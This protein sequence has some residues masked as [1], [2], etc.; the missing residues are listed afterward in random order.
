MTILSGGIQQ[1]AGDR[2]QKVLRL[3]TGNRLT[4][5]LTGMIVTAIIQS[6]S[7]TTVMV[8][9]FVSAGLLTLTQSIGVIMGANIGTTVTAWIVSWMGFAL[10]PAALALP[11]IGIGMILYM[12][13][14]KY[15]NFG[16]VLLGFG[17]VFLGLD[18]LTNSVPT[19]DPAAFPWI[20]SI[21]G[22]SFLSMLIGT[23]VG[24]VVT[25]IAHSSA[26]T[27]AIVMTM[28]R[29]GVIQF[30]IAA[31]MILGANIGTTIDAAL[32]A[33]GANTAAK[34]AALVHILF[35]VIGTVWAL[36]FLRPLIFL[37][38]LVTPGSLDEGGITAHLAMLHTIFNVANTLFFFPFVNPFA[39]LVSLLIKDKS[40]ELPDGAEAPYKLEYKSGTINDTPEWNV[41]RAEKEIRDMAGF[42][43]IMYAEVR[44]AIYALP[45]AAD[46]I[47]FVDHIIEKMTQKEARADDIR[48]ELTRFL[49]ECTR[50][51]QLSPHF[52]DRVTHLLRIVADLEEMTDDCLGICHL[53][54]RSAKKNL[55]FSYKE[56]DALQPYMSLVEYFLGFVQEHLGKPLTEDQSK[57]AHAME[58]Q[59]VSFR[60]SLRKMGRKRIEA[61]K[62]VKTELLF[63]DLVRS[64]EKLG[65]FCYNISESLTRDRAPIWW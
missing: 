28:A 15:R 14:W 47:A 5:V 7:A 29:N 27:T 57:E 55:I 39:R 49:I 41:V 59:I 25:L 10:S 37:V 4:G 2:M 50:H 44:D 11:A 53:L 62:D 63:I 61:G 56:M 65:D 12:T 36:I 17:F 32:A 51:Q 8:V 31:A 64:I 60:D 3:M 34:R 58:E 45:D 26:A 48:D 43:A 38:D 35:N 22:M 6:S 54:E 42:T 33:I 20:E 18:F 9:S 16:E 19:I 24:L 13:K 21:S 30:D 40:A 1:T 23:G 52:D 46:K